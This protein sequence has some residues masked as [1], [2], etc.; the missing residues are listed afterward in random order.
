MKNKNIHIHNL[1]LLRVILLLFVGFLVPHSALIAQSG[2]AKKSKARMSL[3]YN[4]VNGEGLLIATVKT[5]IDRAYQVV[6][7]V[8]VNFYQ[9]EIVEENLLGSAVSNNKGQAKFAL[10]EKLQ[11]DTALWHTFLAAIENNDE[12]KDADKDIEVKKA[13][14]QMTLEVEDSTNWARVFVGSPDETGEIIPASDVECKVFIKRLYGDLPVAEDFD[15]TDE[16]G[17]MSVELPDDIPGDKEGNLTIIA[18]VEDHDD[19]GTLETRQ[20]KNWGVPLVVKNQTFR[21]LWSN[22]ANAPFSLM[23]LVNAILLGVWGTIAIIVVRLFKVFKIG[24]IAT[25]SK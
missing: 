13:V 8:R 16:D 3:Q 23:I 21:E 7:K 20:V 6:P 12:F 10:P 1:S 5:K 19:F 14:L 2:K 9:S 18:R 15:Y 24:K 17:M 11:K 25:D 22:R 4:Q